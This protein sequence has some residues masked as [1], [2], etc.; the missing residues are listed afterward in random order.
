LSFNKKYLAAEQS[1]EREKARV[2]REQTHLDRVTDIYVNSV[3]EQKVLRDRARHYEKE[4][5]LGSFWVRFLGLIL[6]A[7][8]CID[9]TYDGLNWGTMVIAVLFAVVLI[10]W[11]KSR[12]K[13]K[14]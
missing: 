7:S 13:E 5:G 6:I 1:I 4:L 2:A 8:M 9:I 10:L 14:K 12:S 11:L 3:L